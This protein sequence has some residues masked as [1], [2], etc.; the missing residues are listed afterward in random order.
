M[1]YDPIS[2]TYMGEL[3]EG[4]TLNNMDETNLNINLNDVTNILC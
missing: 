1:K 2:K 4:S 3:V